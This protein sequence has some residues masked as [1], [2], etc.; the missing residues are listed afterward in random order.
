MSTVA[1]AM[2]SGPLFSHLSVCVV[3]PLVSAVLCFV[4]IVEEKSQDKV[5]VVMA[6]ATLT[7]L[8]RTLL[9]DMENGGFNIEYSDP[10]N[11]TPARLTGSEIRI[12]MK[13]VE[14]DGVHR[15]LPHVQH[16]F[17][18]SGGGD[19]ISQL[20]TVLAQ[21]RQKRVL[22]FCNTIDSCRAVD[23]AINED[24]QS[25]T[26]S[27]HGDMNSVERQG[28]MD[29][30]RRGDAKILVCTDIAARGIDIPDIDHVV[31]FDFPMNPIDY[32]HRA[33]RCGRAGR[34]GCVTSLISKR[35]EVLANAIQNCIKKGLPIDSLSA[36]KRDYAVSS[37]DNNC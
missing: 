26:L 10:S 9:E 5:Q 21:M 14:V 28:N 31:M 29:A 6:T 20:K 36:S 2:V 32:L 19:K 18:P 12:N 33:G 13:V 8:V 25:K 22:V 34:K 3:D 11:K 4:I 17:E 23:Y 1:M 30:F 37:F 27:Y 15:I 24:G 16:K 35:D 7:K